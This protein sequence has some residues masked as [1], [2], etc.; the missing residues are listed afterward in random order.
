M[1]VLMWLIPISAVLLTIAGVAFVWAVNNRQFDDL[2]RHGLDV[3]D[4]PNDTNKGNDSCA[5]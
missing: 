5:R 4:N 2:D 3:L 1:E